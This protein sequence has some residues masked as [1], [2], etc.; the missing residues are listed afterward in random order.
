MMGYSSFHEKEETA[1]SPTRERWMTRTSSHSID[2]RKTNWNGI[3][4]IVYF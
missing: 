1:L 2:R 3:L 4:E